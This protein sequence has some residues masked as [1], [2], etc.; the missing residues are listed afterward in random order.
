MLILSDPG[1]HLDAHLTVVIACPKLVE[2]CCRYDDAK[3]LPA[4]ALAAVEHIVQSVVFRG[5][6]FVENIYRSVEAIEL[7]IISGKHLYF[8]FS[9][10]VRNPIAIAQQSARS[11]V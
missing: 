5:M 10:F 11:A 8:R 3:R 7:R 1:K 4:A 9:F 6:E 2:A